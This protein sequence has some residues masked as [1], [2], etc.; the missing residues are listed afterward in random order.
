[1]GKD[2]RDAL[3]MLTS[4]TEYKASPLGVESSSLT[5]LLPRQWEP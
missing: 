3:E 4:V 1:M 5:K 2:Q